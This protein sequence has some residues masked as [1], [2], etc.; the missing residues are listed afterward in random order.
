MQTFDPKQC[1]L[2][3]NGHEVEGYASDNALEMP[4]EMEMV[5]SETGADGQHKRVATAERGGQV[6]VYLFYNSRSALHFEQ[7]AVERETAEQREEITGSF[8][9]HSTGRSYSLQ[10][11]ELMMAPRGVTFSSGSVNDRK[12]TFDFEVIEPSVEGA[13]GDAPAASPLGGGGPQ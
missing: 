6:S 12:F 4:D 10:K 2:T 8:Q 13:Q 9:D 1:T 3:I 11:G 5:T 7:L